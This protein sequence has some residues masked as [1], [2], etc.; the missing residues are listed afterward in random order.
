M[1]R[2]GTERRLRPRA[3]PRGRRRGPGPG[4][5]LGRRRLARAPQRGDRRGR[6]RRGPLRL[7]LPLRRPTGCATRSDTWRTPGSRCA[8]ERCRRPC[9]RPRI[10]GM[11]SRTPTR[12]WRPSRRPAPHRSIWSAARSATCCSAAAA[13][14]STW[15]SSATRPSWR[16]GSAPPSR[17]STSASAPRRPPRR[18]RGRHRRRRTESYPEPGA[19]PLVE[20]AADIER[21]PRAARL[22]DQRDGGAAR[23]AIRDLIDPHGGRADLEAGLLRVL[24]PGSFARRPDPGAAR[25]PLR[26]PVRLRARA[27]DRGAAPRRRPRRPSPPTAARPSCCGSR[28][29]PRRSRG[30]GCSPSGG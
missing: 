15:S 26:G 9:C 6:R 21:R 5:R 8:T 30:L 14:T 24:H 16:P 18:P 19:L 27:G 10:S 1:D 22:H 17:P 13:P 12:S 23:T 28:P 2:D 11:R 20:P 3:D 4:D 25:R 29:S 7:D